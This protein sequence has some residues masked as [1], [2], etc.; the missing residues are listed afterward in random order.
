MANIYDKGDLVRITGTFTVGAVLTDPTT[1]T[2]TVKCPSGSVNIYTYA[3]AAIAKTGTGVFYKDLSMDEVGY[4]HY[5]WQGTGAV[6]SAFADYL[7]VR[8]RQVGT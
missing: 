4:W 5:E 1:I 8:T 2:L 3:L 7:I 6:E